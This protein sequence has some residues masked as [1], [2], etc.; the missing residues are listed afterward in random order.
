MEPVAASGVPEM[1]FD[2]VMKAVWSSKPSKPRVVG[3]VVVVEGKSSEKY[4]SYDRPRAVH[5]VARRFD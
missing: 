4:L 5:P 2:W 3:A 1:R